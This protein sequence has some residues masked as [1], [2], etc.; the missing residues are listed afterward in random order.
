MYLFPGGFMSKRKPLAQTIEAFRGAEGK[1]LRL[2]L[3]AQVERQAKRV[4]RLATGGSRFGFRDH[5]IELVT[6]DLPTD[7]YL[8]DVRRRR[9]L[10]GAEPLGGPRPPP[11]R[12]DRARG[13]DHHQRQRR[14]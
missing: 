9:C 4:K 6:A 3:K 2:V 7:E 10:P 12:G 11:L 1:Q 5:R 8:C 14:R 13:P